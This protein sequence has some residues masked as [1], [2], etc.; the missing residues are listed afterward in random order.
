MGTDANGNK[1]YI[2]DD[3]YGAKSFPKLVSTFK[4]DLVWTLSD[5]YMSDYMGHYA[6][7]YNFKL[8]AHYPAD[9]APQLDPFFDIVKRADEFVPITHYAAR[10]FSKAF[11]GEIKPHIYHGVDTTVFSPISHAEKLERRVE[12]GSMN[13]ETFVLGYVGHNQWRKQTWNMFLVLK[14]L[15]EGA[16]WYPDNGVGNVLLDKWDDIDG[17]FVA[18]DH[19]G[20]GY[21]RAEPR[22][23]VLWMHAFKRAGVDFLPDQLKTIFGLDNAII[24]TQEMQSD[25]GISDYEMAELYRIFDAY[26]ALSGGEGFCIPIIE[27]YA[28]GVPV[29]Y[30]NYSGHGEIGQFAGL[31]VDYYCLQ[32]NMRNPINRAVTD[33]SSAVKQIRR[34]MDDKDLYN[35]CRNKGIIAANE[36]FSWDRIALQWNEAIHKMNIKPL[37]EQVMGVSI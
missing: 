36:V 1:A 18:T 23:V 7:R 25:Q 19:S 35:E 32:P 6:S 26:L 12:V 34:L 13:K 27:A 31:P 5:P 28:S 24:Y 29:V 16:Y 30:T 33:I 4:P 17:R 9:G 20:S 21:S 37:S 2:V 3:Q 8:I 11:D 14:Y 10:A 15:R 22:D